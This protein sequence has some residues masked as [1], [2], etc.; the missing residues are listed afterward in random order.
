[1]RIHAYLE[2]YLENAKETLATLF[3]YALNYKK[4]DIDEFVLK[5]LR[6]D[7]SKKFASGD[8]NIISGKS[9]IELYSIIS[10]DNDYIEYNSYERSKEF[11]LGY[12]LAFTQWYLNY[13]FTEIFSTINMNKLLDYYD[14]Y[15]EVD[16][17]Y[18]TELIYEYMKKKNNLSII[19]KYRKISQSELSTLS[20]ISINNIRSYE[21]GKNDIRNSQFNILSSISRVLDTTVEDLVDICDLKFK[22]Y[23]YIENHLKKIDNKYIEFINII[24]TKNVYYTKNKYYIL[25][26][27]SFIKKIKIHSLEKDDLFKE[28][29]ENNFVFNLKK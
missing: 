10:D 27:E 14:L 11:W 24:D 21:Q 25:N 15:H 23:K 12:Y 28:I 22:L 4:M 7:V 2:T 5:F 6:S 20:Q 3:D 19:R 26:I 18:F 13:N 16:P 29:E 1:M 17:M 8:P 9:G